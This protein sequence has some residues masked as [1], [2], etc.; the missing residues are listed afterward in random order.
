MHT[1]DVVEVKLTVRPEL[2]VALRAG[3][4]EPMVWLLSGANVIV[5]EGKAPTW[6]TMLLLVEP[7]VLV[8]P[9]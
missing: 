1:P 9:P 6:M 3:G 8:S 2:A 7:R 4:D 5:W